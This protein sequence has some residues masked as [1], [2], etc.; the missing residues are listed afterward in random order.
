MNSAET[1]KKKKEGEEKMSYRPSHT[2]TPAD[3]D[4]PFSWMA[5]YNA[6]I[7]ISRLGYTPKKFTSGLIPV[8]VRGKD[9]TAAFLLPYRSVNSKTVG[10]KYRPE[11]L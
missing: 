8:P 11:K 6:C 3:R 7:Y 5:T 10:T 4:S 9:G 2:Q 1:R